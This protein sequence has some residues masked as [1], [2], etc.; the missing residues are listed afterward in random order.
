MSYIKAHT[1]FPAIKKKKITKNK[2]ENKC[3]SQVQG[4]LI[5]QVKV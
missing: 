1:G 2:K 5:W 3:P 4:L